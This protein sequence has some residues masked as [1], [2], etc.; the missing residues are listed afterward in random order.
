MAPP[1]YAKALSDV[2]VMT[3]RRVAGAV[4]TSRYMVA[5]GCV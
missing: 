1:L 5:V 4:A 2:V 3:G